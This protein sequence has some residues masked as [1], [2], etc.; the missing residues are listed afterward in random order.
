MTW[1]NGEENGSF[2]GIT[3]VIAK[4]KKTSFRNGIIL[5]GFVFTK[6]KEEIPNMEENVE[7][8]GS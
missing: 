6:M 3:C 2:E 5:G 4:E 1:Q 7:R 8:G